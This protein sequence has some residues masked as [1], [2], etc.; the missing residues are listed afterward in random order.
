MRTIFIDSVD[1]TNDYLKRIVEKYTY[2]SDLLSVVAYEQ[3][4]GRGRF[5]RKWISSIDSLTFS[6]LLSSLENMYQV[7]LVTANSLVITLKNYGLNNV[8]I[9]WPNDVYLNDKKVSGILLEN[10]GKYVIVGI[11]IN[12]NQLSFPDEIKNSISIRIAKGDVID[13]DIFYHD[14]VKNFL[15]CYKEWII[16][17]AAAMSKIK[18]NIGWIGKKVKLVGIDNSIEGVIEGID[19]NGFLLLK[20]DDGNIAKI[21]SGEISICLQA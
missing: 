8:Y 11:G 1:S 9:K 7:S 19:I 20:K 21:T 5:D 13:K 4:S 15:K 14:L 17:P 3:K 18:E 10:I 6:I 12:V 16:N 2:I